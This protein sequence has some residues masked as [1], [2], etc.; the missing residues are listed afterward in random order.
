MQRYEEQQAYGL[1][2][3]RTVSE[4]SQASF[5]TAEDF[6]AVEEDG[7]KLNHAYQP[8][9]RTDTSSPQQLRPHAMSQGDGDGRSITVD[10]SRRGS[11]VST[12]EGARAM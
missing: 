10:E 6:W 5:A 12:W 9:Q 4:A 7:S 2:S 11:S 1:G 3:A 8:T